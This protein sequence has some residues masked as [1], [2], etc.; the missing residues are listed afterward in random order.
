[1]PSSPPTQVAII[2]AGLSG[3][4]FA[5]AL[6]KIGIPST[7]WEVRSNNFV[8]G[9][10][11][12]LSPNALRILDAIGVYKR[13]RDKGFHF[14]TLTFKN[15]HDETTDVYYFG[16]EQLYGYKAFRVYRQILIDELKLM[17]HERGIQVKYDTKFTHV[18]AETPEN[19]EFAFADGSV[20]T[21]SLLIGADGIHSTLRKAIYPTV[22]PQYLGFVGM[23]SAIQT[24]R[25]HFPQSEP[26]YPLPVAIAAG[27]G[28][29]V[30]APQD[31]D[32]SEV[33][34]GTQSA[35]REQDR[36]GWSNLQA[37]K[38]EV[39]RLFSRNKTSWPDLV[40][41]AI[42]NI[43][44]DTI[45]TWPYYAVPRLEKWA[46]PSGKIIILGDAAHAVPPTTGQGVNQ[47]FEDVWMLALLLRELGEGVELEEAL[48]FWQRWRQE[49]VDGILDL[50]RAMN[51]KRLPLAEQQRLP[52]GAVW[53]GGVEDTEQMGWL[54]GPRLE[55]VVAEW[56]RGQR[57]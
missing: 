45:N 28:A 22:K 3:L 32:G 4:S 39:V 23:T 30:I 1:M 54:Y 43:D 26:H 6:H 16:H 14:E 17:L 44:K 25:L 15:E 36:A 55:D 50:T 57:K 19:V 46:S 42:E 5:L 12:M 31:V 18:I 56:V 41:S 53:S 8:Q 9:G 27:P 40:Q 49:R 34:I 20:S 33:L 37:D 21:A 2:G 47:A 35:L 52:K 11:I 13:I 7:I 51:N 10:A 24:S 38:D 29:F 48:G